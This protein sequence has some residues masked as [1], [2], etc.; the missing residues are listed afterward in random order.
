MAEPIYKLKKGVH[1]IAV[2]E[3][4]FI[5][6]DGASDSFYSLSIQRSFKDKNSGEWKKQVISENLDDALILASLIEK[7]ATDIISRK[8]SPF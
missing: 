4:T 8:D 5:T 1:E 6:K 2:F 7:V 3:N